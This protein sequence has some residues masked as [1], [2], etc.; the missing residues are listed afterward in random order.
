MNEFQKFKE[1]LIKNKKIDNSFHYV[2]VWTDKNKYKKLLNYNKNISYLISENN[3]I[4]PLH[5]DDINIL[6]LL[7]ISIIDVDPDTLEN[8][9]MIYDDLLKNIKMNEEL[10]YNLKFED[11][12]YYEIIYVKTT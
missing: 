5:C 12:E 1:Y 11:I 6:I 8:Y 9:I 10:K 3:K 4:I 7:I 2:Y